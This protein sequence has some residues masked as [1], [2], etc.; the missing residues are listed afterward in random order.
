MSEL[1]EF[2]FEVSKVRPKLTRKQKCDN[3]RRHNDLPSETAALTDVSREQ[4]RNLQKTDQ[5]LTKIWE[6]M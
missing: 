4:L 5:T 2:L 1:D 6:G 3:C